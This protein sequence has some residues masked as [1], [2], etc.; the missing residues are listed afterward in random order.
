M[1]PGRCL[2]RE[3]LVIRRSAPRNRLDAN[4][5]NALF[6]VRTLGHH[7]IGIQAI[8]VEAVTR[9]AP[10]DDERFSSQAATR[11]HLND[12]EEAEQDQP[13]TLSED[14]RVIRESGIDNAEV[15]WKE[16]REAVIAGCRNG[17]E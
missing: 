8:R 2:A 12:L 15:V 11:Q 9:R 7:E 10:T 16:Y 13:L 1:L 14:L 5:L 3:S 6:D 17:R 4:N